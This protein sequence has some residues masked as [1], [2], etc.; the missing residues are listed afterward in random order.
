MLDIRTLEAAFAPI[1]QI[2]KGEIDVEVDGLHVYMRA[3]TP[4]EDVAVQ[5]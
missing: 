4:E 5:K 3:L 2:G 1:G